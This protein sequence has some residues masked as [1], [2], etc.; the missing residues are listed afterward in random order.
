MGLFA[1]FDSASVRWM[2]GVGEGLGVIGLYTCSTPPLKSVTRRAGLAELRPVLLDS[3]FT[4]PLHPL[5]S[6]SFTA[7][8]AH[9]RTLKALIISCAHSWHNVRSHPS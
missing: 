3:T 4:A 8:T 7:L 5:T 9:P 6:P 1:T 2:I